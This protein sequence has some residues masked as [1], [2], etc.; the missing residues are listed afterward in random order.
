MEDHSGPH[1]QP[2]R[3]ADPA[4]GANGVVGNAHGDGLVRGLVVVGGAPIS[5]IKLTRRFSEEVDRGDVV[6]N[7]GVGTVRRHVLGA[8][9]RLIGAVG[10]FGE[11][12]ANARRLLFKQLTA[13]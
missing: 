5:P 4:T 7:P 8:S 13:N 2:V 12:A 6:S 11:T 10:G 1:I 3:D 9:A